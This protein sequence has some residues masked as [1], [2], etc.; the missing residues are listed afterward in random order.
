M[1]GMAWTGK[2]ATQLAPR[3]HEAFKFK[4]N[5]MIANARSY[6]MYSKTTAHLMVMV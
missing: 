3:E 1:N 6:H 2:Q 4:M 5:K